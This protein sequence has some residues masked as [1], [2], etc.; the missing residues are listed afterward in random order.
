[1]ANQNGA[2][3]SYRWHLLF[4]D[5]LASCFELH[6]NGVASQYICNGV[7]ALSRSLGIVSESTWSSQR[8]PACALGQADRW[9][10]P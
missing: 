2:R 6:A 1:M 10:L 8:L 3:Q 7:R 5:T 9:K 4:Q